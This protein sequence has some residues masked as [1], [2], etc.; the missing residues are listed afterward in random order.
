MAVSKIWKIEY[1]LAKV[2]DYAANPEKTASDIYTDEDY[3]A[4]RDVLAYAKDEEKT[5]REFFVSGINC[6]PS[7]AREQFVT[8]KEQFGKT[9]GI[10]AYHGYLSFKP[11]E[12]TPELAHQIGLE[13][14]SRVWGDR[15]QV[16]VSTH[17][18]THCL[19]D[20]FVINS[21]SFADGKRLS[22]KEKAWFSLHQISDD[23]CREHGLYVVEN[24]ERN[25]DSKFMSKLDKAGMPTRYEL[26]RT[27]IDE[28]IKSSRDLYQFKNNLVRLGY[29]YNIN[30][31]H[32]YWTITPKGYKKPIR[33]YRLGDDYTK[34]RIIERI[35]E[36]EITYRM[37]RYTPIKS[38]FDIR[39]T[40]GS[41]YNLYLFYCYKI[42]YLP[43]KKK[44]SA[45]KIHYL[46]RED[47]MYL[48]K[49]ISETELLSKY[50]ID[51]AEQLFSYKEQLCKSA[52]ELTAKRDE[53]RKVIKR[54][55]VEGATISE[56]KEQIS[57]ITKKLKS[58][59]SEIK[60]CDDIAKRSEVMEQNLEQIEREEKSRNEKERS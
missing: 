58:I 26:A 27:A 12:V 43:E 22:D 3:Q 46:L 5:E 39:K 35:K 53:L 28:A 33:I 36:N 59:N 21:V 34:D 2:I 57:E 17:L 24:P 45:A 48:D 30:D 54:R 50:Q 49:I 16:V 56:A 15:F 40:K 1:N 6:I 19:H 4:L 29:Y 37:K 32:K 55:T 52:D 44:P 11:D 60:L 7:K 42:G 8:V 20:H 9:G 38:P 51:T 41:L 13:F 23:I 47:L 18:N 14:A 25:P 31:K 10:Q